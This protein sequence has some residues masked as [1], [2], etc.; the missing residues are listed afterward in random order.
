MYFYCHYDNGYDV[1]YYC[2]YP[3]MTS[4]TTV[5]TMSFAVVF[6]KSEGTNWEV[7]QTWGGSPLNQDPLDFGEGCKGIMGS[8][9]RF[10]G[11]IVK[12]WARIQKL[13][14]FPRS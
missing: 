5:V 14:C 12:S 9:L 7:V 13:G 4:I 8:P 11:R 3:I 1:F 2:S 10:F 6:M